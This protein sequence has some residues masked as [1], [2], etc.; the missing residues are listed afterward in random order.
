M[1]PVASPRAYSPVHPAFSRNPYTQPHANSNQSHVCCAVS[2]EI[3]THTHTHTHTAQGALHSP[4]HHPR[5]KAD[6]VQPRAQPTASCSLPRPPQPH[7]PFC[8]APT[9]GPALMCVCVLCVCVCVCVRAHVYRGKRACGGKYG[10]TPLLRV[11]GASSA[12]PCTTAAH[13][14]PAA[15]AIAVVVAYLRAYAGSCMQ[16]RGAGNGDQH[17]EHGLRSLPR[18]A[19]PRYDL[20]SRPSA[21]GGLIEQHVQRHSN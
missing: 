4:F 6:R 2:S 11:G 1:S 17:N 13:A 3:H 20:H 14:T 19:I 21:T 5:P 8:P 10:L 18:P 9:S 16:T 15:R 12:T 7:L